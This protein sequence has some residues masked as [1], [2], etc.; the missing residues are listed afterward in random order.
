MTLSGVLLWFHLLGMAVWIGGMITVGAIVPSL[1]RSGASAEQLRA[2]ARAF[3]RVSWV[4]LGLLVATGVWQLALA[5]EG[6][7]DRTAFGIK[8]LLVGVA[9]SFALVH[10]MTARTA[11]PAARGIVQGLIL[12]SSLGVLA[13]AV[14]L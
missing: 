12:L 1:R 4:A 2:M 9:A 3:G 8:L 6:E 11:S 7:L 5:D 13:A 14:A 10:Q